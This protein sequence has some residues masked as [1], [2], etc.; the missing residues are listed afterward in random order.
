MGNLLY[1]GQPLTIIV[2]NKW[3][4]YSN[5]FTYKEEGEYSYTD[6]WYFELVLT[7]VFTGFLKS[8]KITG[9]YWFF[10]KDVLVF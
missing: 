1:L 6:Y 7:L 5:S 9:I 8:I 3:V 4:D 10:D 2:H